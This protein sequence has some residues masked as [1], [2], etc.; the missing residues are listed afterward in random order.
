MSIGIDSEGGLGL[1]LDSVFV[2]SKY[3]QFV[4]LWESCFWTR[5]AWNTED[6]K[7]KSFFQVPTCQ[8]YQQTRA[9]NYFASGLQKDNFGKDDDDDDDF[10]RQNAREK[11][12]MGL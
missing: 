10:H 9:H 8:A 4:W 1:L 12:Q 6:L 5:Q 11:D 7:S 2:R 3:G